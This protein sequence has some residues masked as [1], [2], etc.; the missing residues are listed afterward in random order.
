[1]NKNTCS[2][3]SAFYWSFYDKQDSKNSYRDWERHSNFT[4]LKS[5]ISNNLVPVAVCPI[6]FLD[7]LIFLT[8]VI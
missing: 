6:F 7:K 5:Y 8:V 4:S 1:L 2:E 3:L